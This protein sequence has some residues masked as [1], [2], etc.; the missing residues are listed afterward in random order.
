V[1]KWFKR[2]QVTIYMRKR[3][4][5]LAREWE[6]KVMRTCFEAV[7]ESLENDRKFARKLVQVA[8]RVKNLDLAKA[9]Q[10]WHHTAQSVGQRE[11]EAKTH[12]SRSLA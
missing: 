12:G 8:Q 6:L 4:K 3:S 5:K 7:K 2:S 1:R 9:F 10:H 11:G